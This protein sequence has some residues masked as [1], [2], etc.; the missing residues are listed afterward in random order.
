MA[1]HILV[2]EDNPDN[3]YVMDRIL[4]HS[5]YTVAQATRAEDALKLARGS[6]FDM[7]LMDMQMPGLDGYSA[8]RA[9]R[10]LPAVLDVPI[11]AVTANSMPGDRQRSLD[12]GCND[13]MAKPID[14]RDLL[15]LVADYLGGAHGGDHSDR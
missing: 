8:V 3:M 15:K 12:A 5:G 9:L 14:T 6:S 13:Y 10:A 1:K 2:V 4:T 7:I 11:I